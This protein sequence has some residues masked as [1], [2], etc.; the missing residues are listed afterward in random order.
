MIA[1]PV[2][3]AVPPHDPVNHSVV[4]PGAFDPPD[5]VKVVLL[6][7]QMVVV[8]VAPVGAVDEEFTVILARAGD[9]SLAGTLSTCA[10]TVA[11]PFVPLEVNVAVAVPLA[12]IVTC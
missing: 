7:L 4:A 3:A 5:T 11:V 1:S 9:V 12:W 8:P 10:F 6:P 2:P